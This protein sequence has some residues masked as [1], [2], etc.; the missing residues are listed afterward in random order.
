[1]KLDQETSSKATGIGA[2]R[3]RPDAIAKVRGEFEYAP[4][5]LEEGMLW[6]ATRRSEY[7]YARLI[8]VNLNPAKEMPGVHAVLGGW[9]VPDNR[10]GAINND[11]PVLADDYVRYVGEP[12]AIVAAVDAETARLAAAAIE[13]EYEPHIPITDPIEALAAGKIYRHIKYSYGD[14]TVVGEVQVEG[15]YTTARQDH[16][17]MAPDAGLARPD[18][19]GGVEVIGATQWVHA[20]LSQVAASLGLPQE[21]V[22]IRNVGI[23]GSFGGRVSMTWQIHGAL[24]AMHTGRPVKFLYTRKETFH[25]RYHRHPSRIWIRHHATRDGTLLKV[26]ARLLYQGGPY[27]HTSAAGI[28]NGCTLIQGPYRIPNAEIEGWAVGTNNG[29]CGPLRGFGVLQAVFACESNI[30]KLA[31]EL[32]MDGGELRAK[33]ALQHGDH[34]IFRQ[35]QDRPTPVEEIIKKCQAMPLPPPLPDDESKINPVHLPGGIA[36]PTRKKYIKRGVAICAAAK[37]IC[38]SEGAP[39]NSTALITLRDGAATIDCAAAEVGQGFVTIA[40]QIVQ[41]VLGISKVHINNPDTNMPP[42]ATTD[43]SQ[44]TVASGTAIQVTAQKLKER[45][46]K[47]FAREHNLDINALDMRDDFVVDKNGKH[48]MPIAEAGMGLVF[49]A[50]ERFD[51]RS[52]R[53][54]EDPSD[55]PVH[56]TIGFSANRCVVDVDVE[57]GLVKVVQMDVVHDIGRVI[58]PMQ[59]QGQIEGGAVQGMGLGLM[60][61][62][63]AE[64]G[65]LLNPDWRSYHIPT[66]VDAPTIH[67]D[68]VCYPEPGYYYGWKGIGEL[69]HVQAPAAVVAA[70]RDATGLELPLAPASPEYVADILNNDEA[71]APSSTAGDHRRGPWKVP[72]PPYDMGPWVSK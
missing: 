64:D 39:I 66:I 27:S 41:T 11:Q 47:F 43:G 21:K 5:L 12:I 3:Q 70:I 42:A 49:R 13:I 22:L 56:V 65:Y 34:W 15:T 63:K 6:G 50:T 20:D 67:V 46:L 1:M 61:N 71:M 8:R 68:F 23:G 58:N 62:L 31:R 2:S 28:G 40:C 54:I 48:L 33:N 18:G 16:S 29:M 69:P 72:P 57:L 38:L 10:F 14:P 44:Q 19:Q 51:Q 36:T 7:P 35:V 17:F 45:F 37:N 52:T 55:K 24:L 53:A 4:D 59:A 60:E 9:D 26:E 25:A 32:K 30:T